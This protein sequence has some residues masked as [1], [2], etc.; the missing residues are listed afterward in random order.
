MTPANFFK[1][2]YIYVAYFEKL[3]NQKLIWSVNQP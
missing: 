2:F 3:E 1:K